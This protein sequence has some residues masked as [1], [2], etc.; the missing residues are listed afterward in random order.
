MW[1]Q[2]LIKKDKRNGKNLADKLFALSYP[3]RKSPFHGLHM[4]FQE[5]YCMNRHVDMLPCEAVASWQY[6]TFYLL[7]F[8]P[9]FSC[10]FI[11]IALVQA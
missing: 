6:I 8:F 11:H 9:R 10:V 3:E 4:A 1:R 2:A 5:K 7:S